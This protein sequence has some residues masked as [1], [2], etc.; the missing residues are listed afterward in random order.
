M[1]RPAPGMAAP[2][3]IA[4]AR[5]ALARA[6]APWIVAIDPWRGL[7][8][9]A[10][11]LGRWL[12]RGARD[13]EVWVARASATARSGAAGV[14]GILVLETPFL[15]GGFIALLA[16]RPEAAGRGIG[17]ALVEKARQRIFVAGGRRW[18]YVSADGANRG[19][20]GFYRKLGFARVGRLPDLIRAGST[21]ILLRQGREK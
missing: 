1:S 2:L 12:A 7:G 4:R 16:V 19:A 18:L 5:P 13:Q 3:R 9:R 6:Q 21:E 20:L 8:Y 14:E 11:P 15:L 10:A 17:R